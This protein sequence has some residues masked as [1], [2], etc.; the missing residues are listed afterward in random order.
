MHGISDL[1]AY[2]HLTTAII[3]I[4]FGFPLY[5][6]AYAIPHIHL[7]ADLV[8]TN[9]APTDAYRGAGRPEAT[10]IVERGI[11]MVA[12][13]LG[14][15]PVEIRRR[16]FVQPDQFPYK[17]AAGAIYDSG[18]YE[19]ALNK[20]LDIIDYE[21]LCAEQKRKRAEG[22]LV[23]I[24]F[25]TYVEACGAGPKGMTPW[26]G[27]ESARVRVEQGGTVLVYT[28]SS[29]HGQGNETAFSQIVAEEFSIPIENILVEH[30]DTDSTPEGRGT[31]SSRNT[32]VGG[33]AL[34]TAVQR[35]KEKM[36]LIASHML[37]A[38][39]DD[40]LL[41]DG[42]FF[43]QGSPNKAVMFTEVAL[44]ANTSNNLHPGIEP[45]LETTT[46]WEPPAM[47][48]PFGTHICVVE[49]DK[50]TGKVEITRFVAV[51]DCG[52]QINPM[53]VEGQVHGGI[54]QGIGQALLEGVVY[55]E[56]G[57]L[58]TA[59]LMDYALPMAAEFPELETEST[60]TP[61]P[62]N[63]L[64]AKGV[65]EA[66]TIGSIPAIANAVADALGVAHVDTPFTPEKLWQIIHNNL[67]H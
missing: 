14:M 33:S 39:V 27:Y 53:L 24:G 32:A 21:H 3:L 51:D 64:G 57:Q 62:V 60:V 34:Y 4:A 36:K 59:T 47:T 63:P 5:S 35:L 43:V 19:A 9:K 49:V 11:D 46:F 8:F 29:P 26:G 1:G 42:K 23:G 52:R 16:N 20:A 55:S 13:E 17:S 38:S 50:D 56:E 10:Y 40:V 45:G 67:N 54:A 31:F 6:G 15:D 30:G 66:G 18:D 22:K 61:T 41:E 2:S 7:S 65:G 58:L 25:S 44:T 48:V 28:G 12:R 37:E